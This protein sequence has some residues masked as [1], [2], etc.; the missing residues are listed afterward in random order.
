LAGIRVYRDGF[1][2]RV[3]RDW[4]KLGGQQTSGGSWYGLRPDN[5]LGYV[6][7]SARENAVL[8]EKT[9]REG[10]VITPYYD[11][12]YE[13]LRRCVRFAAEAEEF[14]R[15]GWNDFR[16]AREKERA[17]I[18][19]AATPEDVAARVMT[20]LAQAT[21]Y[22]AHGREATGAIDRTLDE[23]RRTM[24]SV[25]ATLPRESPEYQ[26]IQ[27]AERALEENLAMAHE[28]FDRT[29][30]YLGEVARSEREVGILRGQTSALGEQIEQMSEAI[31][32]GLTAEALVHEIQNIVDQLARRNDQIIRY[33]RD[34]GS[35]DARLIAY[36]EY[37]NTSIAGLR[38]QLSHFAPSLRYVR[39]RREAIDLL[40]FFEQEIGDYHCQRLEQERIG[41]EIV[42][43]AARDFIIRMN[44]GKLRQIVDNLFLNSEYWLR[45]ELRVRRIERGKITVELALPVVRISDN[46]PGVDPSVGTTLFEPFVTT[47]GRGRGRGL[48]LFVVQQLLDSDGCTIT[49]L[50]DPTGR[51]HTFEIDFT[52]A[53]DAG[54]R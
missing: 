1:G 22:A 13:L 11:N 46:G 35:R 10:F 28:A 20:N 29:T 23:T 53:L 34:Q 14:I 15:R 49:L 6:A 51:P 25:A 40:D 30:R 2:V 12:F 43:T 42:S 45:E 7:I 54:E 27:V 17:G 8:E 47:K 31:G 36:T 39:E 38:K 41:V 18:E 5:T 50:P 44:R 9:D 33:L 16:R 24:R 52:G 21:S 48:G 3:D 37:V 32:L 26:A 19:A 4:L